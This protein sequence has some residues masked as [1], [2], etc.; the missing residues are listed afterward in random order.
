[1]E[2]REERQTEPVS[3]LD[4]SL[5]F[6]PWTLTI[7]V[8]L[9]FRQIVTTRTAVN[10]ERSWATTEASTDRLVDSLRV[11]GPA[12]IRRMMKTTVEMIPLAMRTMI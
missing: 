6:S 7:A 9:D 10:L 4:I 5:C 1:L 3:T 8:Y 12:P 11:R 2:P